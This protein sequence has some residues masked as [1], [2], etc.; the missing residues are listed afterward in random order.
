MAFQSDLVQADMIEITEF[1]HLALFYQVQGVPR[2]VIN[3]RIKIE[4]AIPE[5]AMMDWVREAMRS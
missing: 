2:T 1:P 5:A 3:D 4:G